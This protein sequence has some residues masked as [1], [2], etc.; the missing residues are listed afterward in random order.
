MENPLQLILERLE[1]IEEIDFSKYRNL[2]LFILRNVY[3]EKYANYL[4]LINRI[5]WIHPNRIGI[6][7]RNK[8][9]S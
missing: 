6:N 1:Q 8:Y 9:S 3:N 5:I 2:L 4:L 7:S